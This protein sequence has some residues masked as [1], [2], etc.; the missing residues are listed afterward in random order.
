M[1]TLVCPA[2][3]GVADDDRG[4]IGVLI[5]EA[6]VDPAGVGVL[7]AD[8]DVNLGGDEPRIGGNVAGSWRCPRRRW[9]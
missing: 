1:N 6:R 2:A 4:G 7:S 9:R 3:S 5:G 8:V